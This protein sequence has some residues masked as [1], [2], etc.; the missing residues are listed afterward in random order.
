MIE[1]FV[2]TSIS[3][4]TDIVVLIRRDSRVPDIRA[5]SLQ[6]ERFDERRATV[7]VSEFALLLLLTIF[8]LPPLRSLPD[9]PPRDQPNDTSGDDTSYYTSNN[10]SYRC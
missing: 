1:R 10:R 5:L 3:C 7:C 4:R 8:L 2:V 6:H 9:E